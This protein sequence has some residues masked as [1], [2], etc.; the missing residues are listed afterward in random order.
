MPY[1]IKAVSTWGIV[2]WLTPPG[3]AGRSMAHRSSADVLSTFDDARGAIAEMPWVFTAAGI[4]FDVVESY[5]ELGAAM[6]I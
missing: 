1:L 2:T 3:L 6:R 4:R 5:E